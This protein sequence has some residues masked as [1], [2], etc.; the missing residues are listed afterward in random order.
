M[1]LKQYISIPPTDFVQYI[2]N[3]RIQWCMIWRNNRKKALDAGVCVFS[4]GRELTNVKSNMREV[5]MKNHVSETFERRD[6]V[7]YLLNERNVKD[8]SLCLRVAYA[9]N[10]IW[11]TG[12]SDVTGKVSL[13]RR[14]SF[15]HGSQKFNSMGP[16]P[17][18][19]LD[20]SH[21]DSWGMVYSFGET[22]WPWKMHISSRS[23]AKLASSL[24]DN[25]N[26]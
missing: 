8:V 14:Y 17:S 11:K 19:E 1:F 18:D 4:W 10:K 24:S 12:I 26:D 23:Y 6:F 13:S 20:T 2:R 21:D 25:D 16:P 9:T 5:S 22:Y 7:T 3:L 15:L